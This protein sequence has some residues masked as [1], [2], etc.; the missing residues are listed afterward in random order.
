MS[1]VCVSITHQDLLFTSWTNWLLTMT[2]GYFLYSQLLYI[3]TINY[4]YKSTHAFFFLFSNWQCLHADNIMTQQQV[5]VKCIYACTLWANS[6]CCCVY[7]ESI[8]YL[9]NA[10][11]N[12]EKERE[13]DIT[14]LYGN[15]NHIYCNSNEPRSVLDEIKW[16]TRIHIYTTSR[17]LNEKAHCCYYCYYPTKLDCPSQL[18][19]ISR[20]WMNCLM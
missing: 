18:F 4:I 1:C 9:F 12:W 17:T 10:P 15:Q 2:R 16:H 13:R 5:V 19:F 14:G 7:R 3:N 8:Y 6:G 11:T 20:L